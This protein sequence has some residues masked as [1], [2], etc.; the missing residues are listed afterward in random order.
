MAVLKVHG[1]P[2]SAPAMR[3]L[4]VLQEKGLEFEFVPVDMA[5]GEHK[6]EPFL[7]LNVRALFAPR[8]PRPSIWLF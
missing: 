8:L 7:S 3:V 1:V 5:A 4:A 6:K 2:F